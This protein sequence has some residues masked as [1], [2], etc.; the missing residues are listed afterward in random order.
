[1]PPALVMGNSMSDFKNKAEIFNAPFA[2][3]CTVVKN[4][5]TLPDLQFRTD[6]R[7]NNFILARISLQ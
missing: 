7:L 4:T 3:K 5:S 1:M 2:A 6:H